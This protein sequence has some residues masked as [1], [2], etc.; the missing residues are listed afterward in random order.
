VVLV[1]TSV[2][3]DHL[4]RDNAR[5]AA[6]LSAGRVLSHPFVIGE[7]ACGNLHRRRD[8]LA[9]LGA[10]P[11]AGVVEHHEA[12]HFVDAHRLGGS[13]VGWIDV[14]LMA[15]AALTRCA[16]WTLDRSLRERSHRLDI[17]DHDAAAPAAGPAHKR[18]PARGR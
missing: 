1:D 3:F 16:L 10:L 13:G 12:L 6:L 14:H 9:L 18:P 11:H 2:W 17:P 15:S 4:R 7:V 5:L 8:I